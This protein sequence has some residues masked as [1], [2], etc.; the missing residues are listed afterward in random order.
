M[1]E[2]K[3]CPLAAAHPDMEDAICLGEDCA[4][5]VKIHKSN[6]LSYD[7]RRFVDPE[8][9]LRYNGCGLVNIVPWEIVEYPKEAPKTAEEKQTKVLDGQTREIEADKVP[10]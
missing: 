8:H 5:H 4:C 7:G 10:Y 9:Y 1:P 6:L 2:K 3:L